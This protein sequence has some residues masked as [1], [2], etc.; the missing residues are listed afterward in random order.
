MADGG[1][2]TAHNLR[3]IV[4]NLRVLMHEVAENMATIDAGVHYIHSCIARAEWDSTDGE[5]TWDRVDVDGIQSA[6]AALHDWANVLCKVREE[7]AVLPK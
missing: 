4:S 5:F 2:N 1:E 6:A 3:V 7:W